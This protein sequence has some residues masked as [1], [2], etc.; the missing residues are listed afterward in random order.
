MD[1]SPDLS[2]VIACYNEACHIKQSLP[3]LAQVLEKTGLTVEFIVIDDCSRDGTPAILDELLADL[4]PSRLTVHTTN[5]GRGGTVAEGFRQARGKVVGYLDID[6]EVDPWY[7]LPLLEKMDREK[8][9]G[10]IAHRIYKIDAH[11]TVLIRQ[12]TSIGFRKLSHMFLKLPVTD[13]AGGFKFFR[14]EAIAPVVEQCQ[15]KHWFWDTELVFIAIRMNLSIGEIPVL[16]LRRP[17][18]KSTVRLIPDTI[19][20]FR[21]M[22]QLLKRYPGQVD[23]TT[24]AKS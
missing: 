5:V 13:S 15:S 9:D 2:V 3:K 8:L 14:R 16:F 18:K 24:G 21:E 10:V 4:K 1:S 11:P 12:L 19:R 7:I 20:H 22:F 6:L 17:E 23:D